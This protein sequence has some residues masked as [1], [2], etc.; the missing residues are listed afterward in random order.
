MKCIFGEEMYFWGRNAF[1]GKNN[2]LD[3]HKK[4][5]YAK[6]TVTCMSVRFFQENGHC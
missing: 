3:M 6:D 2:T 4:F 1:I 5:R